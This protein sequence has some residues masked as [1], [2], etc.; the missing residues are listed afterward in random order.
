MLVDI[1]DHLSKHGDAV[2]DVSFEVDD[3]AAVYEQAVKSGA[4]AIKAP[5][6]V[7]DKDGKVIMAV[8]QTYGETTHTLIQRSSYQGAFLPGYRASTVVDPIANFLP[9]ISLEAIDHCVGNQDW[10]E[11]EDACE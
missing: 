9:A 11:M 2:K 6:T 5:E 8:L 1:H 4:K 3:V 7:C 10:N